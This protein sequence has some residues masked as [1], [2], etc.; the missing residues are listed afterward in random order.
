[1][2]ISVKKKNI[3]Y[4]T[5]I[6]NGK[7]ASG[8]IG[9][10]TTFAQ[11]ILMNKKCFIELVLQNFIGNPSFLIHTQPLG[12]KHERKVIYCCCASL[13]CGIPA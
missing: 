3:K 12:D 7:K 5:V 6:A 1:M 4:H 9:H 8:C 10:N 2:M 13:S 11:R